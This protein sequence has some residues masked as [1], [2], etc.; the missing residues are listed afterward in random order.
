MM[1]SDP[2]EHTSYDNGEKLRRYVLLSCVCSVSNRGLER[3]ENLWTWNIALE[4]SIEIPSQLVIHCISSLLTSLWSCIKHPSKPKNPVFLKLKCHR[5]PQ[6]LQRY[7]DTA[8]RWLRVEKWCRCPSWF[9]NRRRGR[10]G[11]RG[12]GMWRRY[13]MIPS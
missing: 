2:S 11:C 3:Y 5:R 4:V 12:W 8:R 6:R 9:R 10:C 1:E 13:N 7:E